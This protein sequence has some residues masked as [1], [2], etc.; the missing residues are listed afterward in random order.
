MRHNLNFLSPKSIKNN[1]QQSS[2]IYYYVLPRPQNKYV[3]FFKAKKSFGNQGLHEIWMLYFIQN[4]Q[5]KVCAFFSK[6]KNPL[7]SRTPWK[8][9]ECC[10]SSK[11]T[12]WRYVHFFKAKKSF[13][14]KDSMKFE[15]CI[16]SKITHWRYVHFFKA[17][18]S[19]G[20]KDSMNEI[21]MLYFIQNYRLKVFYSCLLGDV[22][23]ENGGHGYNVSPMHNPQVRISM[24]VGLLHF[25]IF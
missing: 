1:E 5:L 16:S 20:I 17:K 4:Y 9:F 21:W 13:G 15:C 11:I 2:L 6:P 7:E 14:I 24:Q 3:H 19:F 8:K 25:Y 22:L 23:N 18:K 12:D 10:I